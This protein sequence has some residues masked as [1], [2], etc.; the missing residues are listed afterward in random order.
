MEFKTNYISPEIK[1]S[2]NNDKTFQ[3]EVLFEHHV[4][5]WLMAGTSKIIQAGDSYSFQ[6][7]DIFLVPRNRVTAVLNCPGEHLPHKAV[8]M[9]LSVQQLRE[10]Y[11][12]QHSIAAKP[13]VSKVYHFKKHPLLE[14]GMSSLVPYFDM[15]EELPAHVATLK[16]KEAI[17]IIRTLEPQVDGIL[18]NFDTPGKIDLIKFMETHFMFNLPLEKFGY[19]TGRSLS[20]FNRDFRK[21]FNATP[22]KWLTRRRLELAHHQITV[23]MRK[24]VDVYLEAGFEDLSHFSFAFKKLFGYPPTAFV[25][26]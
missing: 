22:Q 15:H 17:T 7:G 5:I 12:D 20:T 1:L 4:L 16:I 3:T 21:T 19:L 10:Y 18:T 9:L 6:S 25:R 11:A 8:A 14:S 2:N 24:P 26:G 13:A 23:Y